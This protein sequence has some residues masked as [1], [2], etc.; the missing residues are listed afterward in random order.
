[1]DVY[2]GSK[3][4]GLENVVPGIFRVKAPEVDPVRKKG[5]VGVGFAKAVIAQS[6]V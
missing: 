6:A 3:G 4:E 1:M 5:R 2:G